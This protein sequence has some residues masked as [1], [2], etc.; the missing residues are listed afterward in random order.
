MR[1]ILTSGFEEFDDLFLRGRAGQI[2]KEID[3]LIAHS[4]SHSTVPL[5]TGWKPDER[6]AIDDGVCQSNVRLVP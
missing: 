6:P 2:G 4:A 5:C 1:S 3:D